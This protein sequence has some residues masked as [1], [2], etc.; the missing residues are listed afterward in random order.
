MGIDILSIEIITGKIGYSI[1]LVFLPVATVFAALKFPFNRNSVE[2]ILQKSVWTI[3]LL[4]LIFCVA[5]SIRNENTTVFYERYNLFATPFAIIC[6]LLVIKTWFAKYH[7]FLFIFAILL[8]VTFCIPRIM[9]KHIAYG[10]RGETYKYAAAANFIIDNYSSSDTI[11]FSNQQ[12][13]ILSTLYLQKNPE[14]LM[15]VDSN[16]N[17]SVLKVNIVKPDRVITY[18]GGHMNHYK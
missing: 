13:A 18:N 12:V 17:L 8:A 2:S 1:G 7:K 10:K 9:G 14:M 3:P 15:M 4:W 5:V 6:M 16:V 11:V